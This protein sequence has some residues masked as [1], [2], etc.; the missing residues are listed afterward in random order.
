MRHFLQG[1]TKM[2]DVQWPKKSGRSP[3]CEGCNQSEQSNISQLWEK[4]Y[5][6]STEP[7]PGREF[8]V[9]FW[10]PHFESFTDKREGCRKDK[11][12]Q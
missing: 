9:S 1:Q 4:I 3:W 10:L 11:S 5:H 6:V 2:L 8:P 7:A 12:G